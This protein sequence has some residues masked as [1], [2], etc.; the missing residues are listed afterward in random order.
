[1]TVCGTENVPEDE[2]SGT[3]FVGTI[4]ELSAERLVFSYP[5]GGTASEQGLRRA[6][7]ERIE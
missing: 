6:I 1:M 4:E 5:I 3:A 7:Y 2:M